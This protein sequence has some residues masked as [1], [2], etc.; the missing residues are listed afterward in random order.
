M[1]LSYK[2]CLRYKCWETN[3][4]QTHFD[5]FVMSK[6]TV[7]ATVFFE[8]INFL[9]YSS[10]FL[11]SMLKHFASK[12]K[13]PCTILKCKLSNISATRIVVPFI[14]HLH[15]PARSKYP[16]FIF[17]F[18]CHPLLPIFTVGLHFAVRLGRL[19]GG[20]QEGRKLNF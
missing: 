11:W 18:K 9:V 2:T 6:Q 13:L 5:I 7:F 14:V 20:I 1:H 16:R 3:E 10:Y 12:H 8:I 19:N 4:I 15:F 17:I